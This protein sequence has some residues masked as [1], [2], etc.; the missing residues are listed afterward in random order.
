MASLR[1]PSRWH[2][3]DS[4]VTIPPHRRIT[5]M[6]QLVQDLRYALR[7]MRRDAAFCTVAVLI[8]GLGI[9]AN[10]AIFSVV[11]TVLFRPLPFRDPAHLVWIANSGTGGLSAMTSRVSTYRDLRA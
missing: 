1:T 6:H 4:R 7:T 11:N 2:S 9:G 8:L 10:T 5:S 3:T